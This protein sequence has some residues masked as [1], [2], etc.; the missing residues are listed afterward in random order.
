[1]NSHVTIHNVVVV[2][3]VKTRKKTIGTTVVT[4]NVIVCHVNLTDAVIVAIAKTRTKTK[5][6][7]KAMSTTST[8]DMIADTL[9]YTPMVN[10]T[11]TFG[12]SVVES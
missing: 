7:T 2:I 10:L 12:T 8:N 4:V 3:G 9:K 6:K 11:N 5:T 1:M